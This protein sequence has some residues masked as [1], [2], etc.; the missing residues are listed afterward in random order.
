MLDPVAL[1]AA[2]IHVLGVLIECIL[3]GRFS[4]E[5]E[6]LLSIDLSLGGFL[7]LM[8]I[9]LVS[10][11]RKTVTIQIVRIHVVGLTMLCLA[12]IASTN[13]SLSLGANKLHSTLFPTPLI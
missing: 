9:T 2:K 12:S 4:F 10:T 3:Y 1:K 6:R 11:F 5:I 8:I 7:V 13:F